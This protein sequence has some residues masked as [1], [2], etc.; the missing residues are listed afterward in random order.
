MKKILVATDFSAPSTTALRYA[1][2]LAQ[3]MGAKLI[4]LYA[5]TFEPPMEFTSR[6]VGGVATAI[7]D[8]RVRAA[9]ELERCIGQNVSAGVDI[10]TMVVESD[11]VSAIV[12]SAVKAGVDLIVV[13]THG[14][15]GLERLLIGSVSARVV[16]ESP[17]PVLVVPRSLAA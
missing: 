12:G 16:A 17:I 13:G 10:E 7:A 9:E 2:K 14:R 3:E 6:E 5:D 4:A 15:G 11:P 8:S 1:G